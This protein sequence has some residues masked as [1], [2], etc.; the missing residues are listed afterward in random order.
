M[1][2]AR[3][4][5]ELDFLVHAIAYA[6]KEDLQG[7]I[8]DCSAEGFAHAMT[9]SC[10]SFLRMAQLAEPLMEHGGSLLTLT[11]YGSEKAVEGYGLMGPVKAALE[12]C[13]KYLAAELGGKGIRVNALSAGSDRHAG[14]LRAFRG[15]TRCRRAWSPAP[16]AVAP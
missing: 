16:A 11:F 12:S 4:G 14:G 7:R 6:R 15:L 10:H 3:R 2:C 9:V 8:V 13:V 5:A 1:R